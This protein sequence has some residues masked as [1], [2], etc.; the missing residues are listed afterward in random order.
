[1]MVLRLKV[2]CGNIAEVTCKR[3]SVMGKNFMPQVPG[4]PGVPGTA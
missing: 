1:M 3:G 2:G 4:P